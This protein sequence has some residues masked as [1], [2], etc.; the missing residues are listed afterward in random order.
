MKVRLYGDICRPGIV[1]LEVENLE[2]L[3]EV[4]RQ[5][6]VSFSDGGH[7]VKICDEQNEHLVFHW[8]GTALDE[9]DNELLVWDD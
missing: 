8:D 4:L 7:G 5:D 2:A 9:D 3:R 6:P 1:E